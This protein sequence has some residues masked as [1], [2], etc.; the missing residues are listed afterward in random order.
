MN[1]TVAKTRAVRA[2]IVVALL[3]AVVILPSVAKSITAGPH[4][5]I[6]AD[7]GLQVGRALEQTDAF[8]A[9]DVLE[10]EDGSQRRKL[11]S[12]Y[13]DEIG[14]PVRARDV[15]TSAEG[16]VV[17]YVVD[18]K[19]S[20]ALEELRAMLGAKGWSAMGLGGVEGATFA[21][22]DSGYRWIMATCTQVADKTSVVVRRLDV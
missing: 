2:F 1:D 21:K 12:G 20:D 15:R 13:E 19:A 8:K 14:V 7:A 22:Q 3:L 5:G 10:E 17:G 11:P 9:L 16:S 18:G 6:E 4:D